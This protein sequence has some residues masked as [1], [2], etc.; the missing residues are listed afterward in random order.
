MK[1]VSRIL[2]EEF[3]FV[4]SCPALLW[5]LFFLYMPLCML[6][7]YSVVDYSPTLQ[8]YQLTTVYYEQIFN[9]LYFRVII[10]SFVLAVIT[11]CICFLIAY[12]V[13]YFLAMKV[14]KRY[15]PFLLF[16]LILPSWTSLIIQIY[17]WFFLLEKNGIVSQIL[18]RLGLISK[19]FH[20]LNNY[21]SILIGMVSCFLPFMILPIYT[22]L[23]K[24]DKRFLEA[25]ADLGAN[26]FETFRRVVF[27]ISLPGVYTGLLL[28]FIPAFGEF[29]IPTLLGGSKHIFWGNVIVD[30]FL[31]SRDWRSGSALTSFGILFPVIV[32]VSFYIMLRV[33]AYMKSPKIKSR[34]RGTSYKDPWI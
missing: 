7:V 1:F 2:A 33:I 10:N 14:R 23:E 29:A 5:Q 32:I 19:S 34:A 9:S 22:V 21:F 27:P 17:A 24:M 11:S 3:P 4:L 8:A 26:R 20:L 12:P 28:V 25:S 6:L 18:Y 15:R 16:S 31:M 13:A 30:K